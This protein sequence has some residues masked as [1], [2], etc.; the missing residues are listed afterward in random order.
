MNQHTHRSQKNKATGQWYL[1]N[2]TTK[3]STSWSLLKT[4]GDQWNPAEEVSGITMPVPWF[5]CARSRYLA[6]IDHSRI[7]LY[8]LIRPHV[9]CVLDANELSYFFSLDRKMSISQQNYWPPGNTKTVL[10]YRRVLRC[11]RVN[12]FILRYYS[13][14]DVICQRKLLIKRSLRIICFYWERTLVEIF[15]ASFS[16]K[17]D[18]INRN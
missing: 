4:C 11:H 10:Q 7:W 16:G 18:L 3:S 12:I 13:R 14:V 1:R 15:G 2:L 17:G 8:F 6:N 9:T 5:W